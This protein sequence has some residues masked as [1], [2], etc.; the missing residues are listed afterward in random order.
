MERGDGDVDPKY[1]G[2]IDAKIKLISYRLYHTNLE[3]LTF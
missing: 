3:I 1:N 2:C